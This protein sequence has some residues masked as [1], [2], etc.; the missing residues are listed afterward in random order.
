VSAQDRYRAMLRDEIAPS[1]RRRGFKGSGTT[2]LLPDDTHWLQIGFQSSRWNDSEVVKFT[3]NLS[4][5]DKAAWERLAA[6]RGYPNRPRPGVRYAP[7]MPTRR[8]GTLAYGHDH[9]WQIPEKT[10]GV[11]AEV[12]EAIDRAALPWLRAKGQD[13]EASPPP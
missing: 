12:L 11:A 4:A 13:A 2:Y 7:D 5:A 6:T 10:Q 9:W 8:L 1:L 3:V